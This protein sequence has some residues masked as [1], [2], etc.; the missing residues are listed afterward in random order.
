V[1]I[2]DIGCLDVGARGQ[3]DLKALAAD[4]RLE[5]V[6]RALGEDRAA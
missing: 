3:G 2:A 4:R 5:L 1:A 6:G